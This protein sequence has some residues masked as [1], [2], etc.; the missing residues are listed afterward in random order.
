MLFVFLAWNERKQPT[1]QFPS[2]GVVRH[3]R[4]NLTDDVVINRP[5][6]CLA[7]AVAENQEAA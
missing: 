1:S 5:A 7:A 3:A 2:T 6:A 4:G